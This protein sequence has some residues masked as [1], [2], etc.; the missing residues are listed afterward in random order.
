MNT[1]GVI[2]NGITGRVGRKHLEVMQ[3]IQKQGG[4]LLASGNFVQLEPTLLGRDARKL[5]RLG[6]EFGFSKHTTDLKTALEDS[7]NQIYFDASVPLERPKMI[8]QALEAGKHIYAEKPLAMQAQ[9]ALELALAAQSKNLKHGLVQNMLFQAGPRKLEQ[10]VKSGFFG[11]ILSARIDFG[12]WVFE[13]DWQSAQRPSWNYRLEDG[14]GV[15]TDMFPHWNGLLEMLFGRVQAVSTLAQTHIP[16]RFDEHQQPYTATADDT[17]YSLLELEGGIVVQISASWAARVYRDDV[18][19]IQIDGT[20]GS[21]VAGYQSCKVQHRV[22]TPRSSA[23][24]SSSPPQ[25]SWQDLPA[26]LENP[27]PFKSQWEHFVRAVVTGTPF[28]WDFFAA[29]RGMQLAENALQS[30]LERRWITTN[31]EHDSSKNSP[32][33]SSKT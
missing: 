21:A 31:L 7:Q 10:L 11:R 22:N 16:Q 30:S 2:L 29:A 5:E 24:F 25:D 27:D 1:L 13:G 6:A 23:V 8:L 19:N 3:A 32:P 33:R 28:P 12:Y 18:L 26:L 4:V 14:G 17:S 20:H 9:I 15:V